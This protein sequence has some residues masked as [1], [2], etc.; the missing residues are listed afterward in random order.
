MDKPLW[1]AILWRPQD[2]AHMGILPRHFVT[3][4]I[5]LTHRD[6]HTGCMSMIPGSH[7]NDIQPNQ[8]FADILYHGE[9]T[10]RDY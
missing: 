1:G 9:K 3:P 5:A 7:L 6:R 2:A 4:K 10:K 8:N